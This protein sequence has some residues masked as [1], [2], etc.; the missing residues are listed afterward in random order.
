M[1]DLI[2]INMMLDG[3]WEE[4]TTDRGNL[5]IGEM[6]DLDLPVTLTNDNTTQNTTT[7]QNTSTTQN[8]T[9]ADDGATFPIDPGQSSQSQRNAFGKAPR[10]TKSAI[11]TEMVLIEM[12]DGTKKWKCKWCGKLYTYGVK[13][14]STGNGKKHLENCIQI[15]L[16]LKGNTDKHVAQYRL[17]VGVDNTPGLGT[18][19][20]NHVRVRE[21]VAHMILGHEFPFS[22]MEGVIFN[23][24]LREIYPRYKKITRQRVKFDC[25]T[26]YEAER[27]KMKKS[28]FLINRIS[29][30]TDLW[31]SGEQR[32]GYMTVTGH[33][34]DSKW[35]LHKRVLSFKNVPPPHSGEVLC[36]ELIKVMDDWGIT[37]KVISIS[38][39]NASAN[40]NCIVRLKRDY[41]GR[42]NLPL[43]GK[44]FHA[45]CCAHI[46][47]LLVQDGLDMIKVTVNKIRNGVKY[48]LNSDTRCKAFKKIV[49]ELQLK[50]R[51]Q[52]L[53]T[54][55]RWNSI[56][57]MLSTS[58]HYR[59]LWPRYAEE[60]GAFLNYLPDANDWEDAHDICKFLE[61]FANVTSI[62]SGTSY[63]TANLFLA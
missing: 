59:E 29:L 53:D 30:T 42:R 7:I 34:I 24:F 23:E 50:G 48:L 49:D 20:Y 32:M 37:D 13:W 60:N 9:T 43:D 2:D 28:M 18:W 1:D 55:T 27:V 52:V 35:Q 16:R 58:Y 63:P 8:T 39:D 51:M 62:I 56:W 26:L 44:L 41:S 12:P 25:E 31:W 61:V 46:L 57:L 5:E 47:N 36:R 33:F 17:N 10:P 45:R 14:K 54:K 6:I 19:T 21:V 11:H 38:I 40:D 15:K 3:S 22:V 4:E